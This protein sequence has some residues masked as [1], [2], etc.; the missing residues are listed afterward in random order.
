[1]TGAVRF[2]A[3]LGTRDDVELIAAAIAHLRRIGVDLIII[4]DAGSIDGRST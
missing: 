2:V 1:M 4:N 3:I